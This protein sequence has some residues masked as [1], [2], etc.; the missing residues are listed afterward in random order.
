MEA[1]P[2]V[3]LNSHPVKT[4]LTLFP[5][6]LL[7]TLTSCQANIEGCGTPLTES[8]SILDEVNG[9]KTAAE[10]L[11][12]GLICSNLKL[13]FAGSDFFFIKNQSA[14]LKNCSKKTPGFERCEC[15][16]NMDESNADRVKV[17]LKRN[18]ML[19]GWE[20]WYVRPVALIA[21]SI[22]EKLFSS[23]NLV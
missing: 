12:A 3:S 11:I 17:K 10:N 6:G 18:T 21:N 5:W 22:N 15:L 14:E 4:C 9:C 16:Q 19:L 13:F 1:L 20:L 23:P 7:E 2:L 8:S